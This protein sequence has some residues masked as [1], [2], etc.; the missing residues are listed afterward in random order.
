MGKV[1]YKGMAAPDDPIYTGEL[2]IGARLTEQ[3]ST[4]KIKLDMRS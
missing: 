1:I 2:F 3:V 4:S